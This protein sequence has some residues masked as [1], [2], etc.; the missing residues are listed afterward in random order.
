MNNR[1]E[2]I[3]KNLRTYIIAGA[4]YVACSIFWLIAS[5]IRGTLASPITVLWL[6]GA[7]GFIVRMV[8][9][10]N[11]IAKIRSGKLSH[12]QLSADERMQAI[13]GKASSSTLMW[14]A[15][16]I[17]TYTLM[18]WEYTRLFPVDA[19]IALLMIAVFYAAHHLYYSS[20]Y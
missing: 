3:I 15:T 9:S 7:A 14:S 13:V 18:K 16:G 6:L 12:S 10:A 11:H 8:T 4:V 2:E 19:A 5:Y 20:K 1:Q 17:V